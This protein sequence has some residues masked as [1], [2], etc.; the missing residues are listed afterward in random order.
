MSSVAIPDTRFACSR[1]R[2][3]A[4]FCGVGGCFLPR[5]AQLRLVAHEPCGNNEV[6]T[7]VA[8]GGGLTVDGA[9]YTAEQ[10][11]TLA[12]YAATS[13]AQLTISGGKF[14]FDDMRAIATHGNGR[15]VFAGSVF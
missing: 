14:S 7:V 15:V 13:G 2:V 9:K 11:R 1:G 5:P 3:H 12:A 8:N 4:P 10:L 6:R